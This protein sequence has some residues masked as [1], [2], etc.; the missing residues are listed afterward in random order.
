VV[1]EKHGPLEGE[2][3][4]KYANMIKIDYITFSEIKK[5]P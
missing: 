4:G 5:K 2:M 3:G 1:R